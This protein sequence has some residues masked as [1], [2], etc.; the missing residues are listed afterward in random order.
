MVA[1]SQVL[2]SDIGVD[3]LRR[4]GSAADAAVAVAAALTVCE[5]TTNGLGGDCFAL[6]WEPGDGHAG[7]VGSRGRLH[8]L[9]AS[10]RS[11]AALT[12]GAVAGAL[13]EQR[14]PGRRRYPTRGWLPVTVPG[15][16]DG[17]V[18][19]HKR[20]GRLPF[21]ECLAGAIALARDGY[22]VAPQT[23]ELWDRSAAAFG[24]D[25]TWGAAWR[26]VFAPARGGGLI[27]EGRAPRAGESIQLPALAR[28]LESI[29][30]THGESF[31]R[32][33]IAQAIAAHAAATG[34]LITEADLAA[35]A[36][37]WV[38]PIGA[39]YR[40]HR[41][42]EIPPNGQGV[43]A[44]I[45]LGVLERISPRDATGGGAMDPA[46][47]HRMIEAIKLG[48]L[49]AHSHVADAAEMSRRG[50]TPES[51]LAPAALDQLAARFDTSRAQDFVAGTPKPGGTV[52]FCT[53]DSSGLMVSFI[54]SNYTGF[55]SG[56]VIPGWGIAM[57]NRGACFTLEPGHPNEVGPSKR[58]YHTII[59]GFL[60]QINADGS[61]SPAAALGVMGGFMQPQGHV[62]VVSHLLDHMMTPQA[63][64]DMPRWQWMESMTIRVEPQLPAD[65]IEGL[66][67][68]GHHIEIAAK[69]DVAFGRGQIIAVAGSGTGYTGGSDF[70]ADGCV[71]TA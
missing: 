42:L 11:P 58:P 40:G 57:Q 23:A 13:D 52:Q 37:D 70:R 7:S 46:R 32:G 17:W 45:A 21:A 61:D 54:Q 60:T 6:V 26:E 50:V 67:S 71:R 44:L 8:G 55:G 62:Q 38:T 20:F 24:T 28:T 30:A 68:L 3:V 15:Q 19:L 31:Y 43:A 25:E 27:P 9:N 66:R 48:F 33:E 41:L 56:V 2:A 18:Q 12:P 36:A 34:G 16:V 64:L 59:P 29:A 69:A 10:G 22:A 5:P 49:V 35:C 53:A 4:G 65:A 14:I 51:L 47:L 1:T 39:P 63:A